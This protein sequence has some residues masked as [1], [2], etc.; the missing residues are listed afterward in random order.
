M[1]VDRVALKAFAMRLINP[2]L[3][4]VEVVVTIECACGNDTQIKL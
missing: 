1:M 4:G 2:F 3:R